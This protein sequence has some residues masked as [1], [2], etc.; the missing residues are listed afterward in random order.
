MDY[1]ILRTGGKQYKVKPGDVLDVEKLPVE[2]GSTVELTDVMAVSRGGEMIVGTPLVPDASIVAQVR[3][4]D[5]DDKIL[6]FKYKR[7]TRY[8]RKKGHRQP[9]TRLVISS[10]MLNGEEIAV[11]PAPE[12]WV[13]VEDEASAEEI[14]DALSD[15]AEDE[16]E[17]SA[18]EIVDALSDLAEDEDEASAEEIVDAL[19]DLAEATAG[20]VVEEME[21][22][23]VGEGT[24]EAVADAE[25]LPTAEGGEID[26]SEDVAA[27]EVRGQVEEEITGEAGDQAPPPKRAPTRRRRLPTQE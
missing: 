12:A 6:V 4:Q 13:P 3:S 15:L 5:R 21:E 19:S 8:R 24:V 7:K 18:E 14:V 26:R 2:E 27:D 10:I 17:A 1:V 16:D 11:A 22:G 9:Y 20:Q 25:E 23:S